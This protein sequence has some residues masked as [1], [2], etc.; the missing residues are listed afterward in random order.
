MNSAI[1]AALVPDLAELVALRAR[2]AQLAAGARRRSA[3]RAAGSRHSPFRGRGM[4]YAESRAYAAGDDVRHVDWRLT[5]R[6]GELHTKL[7]AAERERTSAVLL[8]TSAALQFGTRACFKSVQAAR[9][10]A[11]FAWFAQSEGDRVCAAAFGRRAAQL[12]AA[13]TQRGVLRVL[14]ALCEWSL[15]E[16]PEAIAQ[17]LSK[18]IDALDRTLRAGAHVLL[19]LEA[20]SLD[21]EALRGLLRLRQHHDVIAAVLVDPLERDTL[22]PGRYRVQTAEGERLLEVP[23]GARPAWQTALRQRQDI[24]IERL[25]RAGVGARL[26]STREDPVPALRDLLRGAPPREGA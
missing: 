7:F 4:D 25:Q 3:D 26:I 17:P 24:A 10:G 19:L 21:E 9:L 23:R 2:A 22:P 11:L 5:A 8:D 16:Q 18:A 15:P 12:P 14:K 20:D 6:T 1:N 13:G